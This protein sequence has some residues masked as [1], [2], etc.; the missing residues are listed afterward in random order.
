[1][2]VSIASRGAV[3]IQE[4]LIDIDTRGVLRNIRLTF[5][6]TSNKICSPTVEAVS[7]LVPRSLFGSGIGSERP[8]NSINTDRCKYGICVYIDK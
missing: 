3:R 6:E 4:S 5:L 8:N 7:L 2:G 1:M